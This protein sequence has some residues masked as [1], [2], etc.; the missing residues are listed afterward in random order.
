MISARCIFALGLFACLIALP[1][2][3]S[4][5]TEVVPTNPGDEITPAVYTLSNTVT[6]RRGEK[7]IEAFPSSLEQRLVTIELGTDPGTMILHLNT[8]LRLWRIPDGLSRID[9]PVKRGVTFS[10]EDVLMLAGVTSL[11]KVMTWGATVEWPELGP[12]TLVVFCMGQEQF[13]GLLSSA[14]S[15]V[16]TMRPDGVPEVPPQCATTLRPARPAQL[17]AMLSA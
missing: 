15:G 8:P 1:A 3:Y 16:R 12:V 5:A 11:D 4:K 10:R 17:H 7:G 14:P 13:G 2:A 6:L 9:W